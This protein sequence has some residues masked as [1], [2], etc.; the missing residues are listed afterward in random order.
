MLI[1]VFPNS[2]ALKFFQSEK[3]AIATITINS[4]NPFL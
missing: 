3:I 4:E 1:G 2:P